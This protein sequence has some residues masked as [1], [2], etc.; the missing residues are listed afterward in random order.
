M[1]IEQT[2]RTMIKMLLVENEIFKYGCRKF[3]YIQVDIN[4]NT[5]DIIYAIH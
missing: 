3:L 4:T 2:R 5:N 1:N